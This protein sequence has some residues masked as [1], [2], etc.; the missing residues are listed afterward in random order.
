[1]LIGAGLFGRYWWET[2][3][4]LESTDD[5]YTAA[6]AATI[7]PRVAGYVTEV[8]V[9]DN[10]SVRAGQVLARLDDRDA[11]A[12]VDRAVANVAAAEAAIH[13]LDA[14]LALQQSDIA[15]QNANIDADQAALTFSQQDYRRYTSLAQSGAGTVQSAQRAAYDIRDKTAHLTHDRAALQA[16]TQQV[17]VLQAQRE[18]AVASLQADRAALRQAQLN[19]GYTTM[20][21]PI[22]GAVGDRSL[23][24]GLYVQPG[25]AVMQIVPMGQRIYVVANFKETQLAHMARGQK[26]MVSV[27]GFPDHALHGVVD[28]LAPGS[29]AQFALLPPENATGNF[30]KIVQRVP[31][32]IRL[33]ADPL[34]DRLRPGL[35]VEATVDLRTTPPGPV[36]TLAAATPPLSISPAAPPAMEAAR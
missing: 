13:D 33:D 3:R 29:G 25:T 15:Q 30:T 28:S 9:T 31:V 19:L 35:S 8:D 26:A 14:R 5:S 22:D 1:V 10:Q 24:L 23:R 16:A 36:Q 27:D 7:S 21:A 32:K 12:A 34:L 4:F 17:N 6:D 18:Q 2:G 11:R 20:T